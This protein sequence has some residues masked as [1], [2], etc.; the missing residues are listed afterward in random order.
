MTIFRLL[1]L[2]PGSGEAALLQDGDIVNIG[3]AV[4]PSFFVDGRPLLYADG[5]ATDGSNTPALQLTLQGAYDFSPGPTATI[6]L[7]TGKDLAIISDNTTFAINSITGNVSLGTA[8]LSAAQVSANVISTVTINSVD[9]SAFHT[10]FQTHVTTSP[11]PKHTAD[12]ISTNPLDFTTFTG[13]NVTEVLQEI[14]TQLNSVAAEVRV[15]EHVQAVASDTWTITHNLNSLR[16]QITLW[17]DDNR[18]FLGDELELMDMDTIQA[19]FSSPCTGR[20]I[21]VAF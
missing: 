6:T 16:V 8:T 17:G 15:Y 9:F 20:A 10:A 11:A 19:T 3:G 2:D 18:V 14:E 21:L 1:Y 5:T 13:T 12:E 7:L 4:G